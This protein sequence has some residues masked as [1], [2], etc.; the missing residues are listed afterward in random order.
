M[1]L[2]SGMTLQGCCA[3]VRL[4]VLKKVGYAVSWTARRHSQGLGVLVALVGC[5]GCWGWLRS[6]AVALAL[7]PPLANSCIGALAWGQL[8]GGIGCARVHGPT[9]IVYQACGG[10]C[11]CTSGDPHAAQRGH[12]TAAAVQTDVVLA[13]QVARAV[14]TH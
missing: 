11:E 10:S 13:I 14:I 7:S 4:C 3:A 1:Q 12:G 2:T 9:N 6:P 8:E 5:A